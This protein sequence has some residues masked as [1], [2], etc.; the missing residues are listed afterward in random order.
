MSKLHETVPLPDPAQKGFLHPTDLPEA[1]EIY[2]LG[3]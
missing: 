1:R 3:W 2:L